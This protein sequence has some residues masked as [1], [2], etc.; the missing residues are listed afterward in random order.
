[1]GQS[2]PVLYLLKAN[3]GI[4]KVAK[5]HVTIITTVVEKKLKEG[6]DEFK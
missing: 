1:V 6:T 5:E 4:C 3:G 2:S